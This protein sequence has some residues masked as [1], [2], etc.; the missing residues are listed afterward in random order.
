MWGPNLFML[1]SPNVKWEI[2]KLNE[3]CLKCEY[4]LKYITVAWEKNKT[5]EFREKWVWSFEI[6]NSAYH[7]K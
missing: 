2:L 1:L 3:T 4:Q 7:A 5:D 6:L